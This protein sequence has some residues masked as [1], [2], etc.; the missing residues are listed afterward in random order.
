MSVLPSLASLTK[1]MMVG[2]AMSDMSP[3]FALF[4]LGYYNCMDRCDMESPARYQTALLT[5]LWAYITSFD[6]AVRCRRLLHE[7]RVCPRPQS[8]RNQSL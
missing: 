1:H 6:I 5:H 7:I 8:R 4:L 3:Y 2:T